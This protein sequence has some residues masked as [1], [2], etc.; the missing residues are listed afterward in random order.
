MW[1]IAGVGAALAGVFLMLRSLLPW[2]EARRSG[3]I[4]TQGAR[5]QRIERSAEPDRF[6]ALCRKRLGGVL[7]GLAM[8]IGG[9]FFVFI[10]VMGIILTSR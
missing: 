2:L 10:Q 5:V 8:F 6:D 3:V 9:G 1:L 4:K 7:P